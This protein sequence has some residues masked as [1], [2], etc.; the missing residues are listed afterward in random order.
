MIYREAVSVS[1]PQQRKKLWCILASLA[2]AVAIAIALDA[3][4]QPVQDTVQTYVSDTTAAVL[5][6]HP[7]PETEI[8][9][10][11]P[12][13]VEESASPET[14]DSNETA[15]VLSA[16]APAITE[17]PAADAV[18]EPA[19][20]PNVTITFLGACAPG[21]PLGTAS[22]GSLNA[23]AEKEGYSYFFRKLAKFFERDDLTLAAN[24]CLFTD[25]DAAS[26][27]LSCAA[28]RKGASVY[29]DS[30]IE[31]VSLASPL[32]REGGKDISGESADSLAAAG[33]QAGEAGSIS[34]FDLKGI[35]VAVLS[36]EL[37]KNGNLYTDIASV[38]EAVQK[39]DF[40][41]VYFWTEDIDSHTPPEWLSYAVRRLAMEG[42][43]LLVGCGSS[44]LLPM[45]VYEGATIAYSLGN[46]LDG[47]GV[48]TENTSAL[49][50][51]TLSRDESGALL[52]S[53]DVIPCYTYQQPWQPCEI[54]SGSD[55]YVK[56]TG[57]LG[58][59]VSS[60]S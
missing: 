51:L 30:S 38:R 21:S 29:A 8:G 18:P 54:P 37:V 25:A 41:V 43:S 24:T 49:L 46:L 33:V 26:A 4:P 53:F 12:E 1:E 7:E 22:Y 44:T 39:A 5:S 48:D 47:T 40:T 34:Y 6:V 31:F 10:V 20:D 50:R 11:A 16:P 15:A 57:L 28:P 58:T 36:T 55:D 56:V 45:E 35:T 19:D 14:S 42:A 52:P 59:D 27:S 60:A 17:L 13:S 9:S 32:N 23:S 3:I 2:L